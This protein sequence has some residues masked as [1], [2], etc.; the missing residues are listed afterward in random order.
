MKHTDVDEVVLANQ[1]K[2]AELALDVFSEVIAKREKA[3][4][5]QLIQTFNKGEVDPKPYLALV[6]K[7]SCFQEILAD[8]DRLV[9]KGR[10]AA[11]REYNK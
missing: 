5:T 4:Y 2:R 7:L 6:G 8:L 1:G 3:A 9:K 11:E 10:A